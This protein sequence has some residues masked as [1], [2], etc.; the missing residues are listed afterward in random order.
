MRQMVPCDGIIHLAKAQR[1]RALDGRETVRKDFG[2]R[3]KANE[4]MVLG[5]SSGPAVTF[6]FAAKSPSWSGDGTFRDSV[7]ARSK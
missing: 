7:G 5:T 6:D 1:Y 4:I 3:E 2:F